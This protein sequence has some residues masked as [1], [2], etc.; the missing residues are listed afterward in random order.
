[1]YCSTIP[2]QPD[3]KSLAGEPLRSVMPSYRGQ[4]NRMR[5][6]VHRYHCDVLM[7]LMIVEA[8]LICPRL[9]KILVVAYRTPITDYRLPV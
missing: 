7:W 9:A 3:E 4:F 8:L 1:M 6:T 5:V 2:P